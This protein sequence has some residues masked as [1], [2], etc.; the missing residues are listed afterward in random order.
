MSIHLKEINKENWEECVNLDVHEKQN[1]FVPSN[2]YSIAQSKF[3]K[4]MH[5]F[6]IY[7]DN[8][9]IGFTAYILD[10][11]GDMNLARFMIDKK[12]QGKGYGKSAL[13]KVIELIKTNFDNK[14]IWISIHP[15]NSTAIHLY[16]SVGFNVTETGLESE[17]EIFLKLDL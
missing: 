13:Q 10:D 9:I 15:K 14:E 17:D 7:N 8:S 12:E 1:G 3:E 6:G 16:N 11:D 4:N 5:M 2:A